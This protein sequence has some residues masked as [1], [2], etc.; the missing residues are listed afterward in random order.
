MNNDDKNTGGFKVKRKYN[1]TDEAM[2]ARKENAKKSTG[3]KTAAGKRISAKNAWKHGLNAQRFIFGEV[4]KRCNKA[5]C[6]IYEEC[7]YVKNGI[8]EDGGDCFPH[9]LLTAEV[10]D[11]AMTAIADGDHQGFTEVAVLNMARLIDV[12]RQCAETIEREGVVLEQTIT[13]KDGNA[14]G[15][16]WIEHP[17]L[18]MMFKLADKLNF[19]P[20][21]YNMTPKAIAKVE[22]GKKTSD[23]FQS[24]ADEMSKAV[25]RDIKT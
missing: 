19:T 12:Y 10:F 20:D 17:A 22:G 16:V 6:T 4:G 11:R 2:A 18:S 9:K 14:A 8:C 13:D 25:N 15:K 21:D 23:A 24:L 3:P 7:E 1:M 5:K